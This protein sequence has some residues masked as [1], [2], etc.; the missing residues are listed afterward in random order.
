M[1][2]RIVPRELNKGIVKKVAHSIGIAG[3]MNE[4]LW[5][6]DSNHRTV[7][8]NPI[9]EELSGYS[10]EECLGQPADFCFDEESKKR[11]AEHHQLRGKGLASKYEATIVS[12]TGKRIPVLVSGAP[13][14][15]GGTIGIFLNLSKLKSLLK[16]ERIAEQ[17][18]K[19]TTDAIVVLDRKRSIKL[20]SSGAT[21]MF[22]YKEEKVMG[23]PIDILIPNDQ[24]E[25]NRILIKEVENNKYVKNVE[26]K[27]VT[28]NGEIIDVTIS[29][30]KVADKNNSFIGYLVIYSNITQQKRTSTELQKR[31]E[32]IQD[33]YKELG[34]Q[35]R[36]ADYMY[37][38]TAA[39]TSKTT[40]IK[41][42]QQLIL[43]AFSLLTKC[44]AATLR[45]LEHKGQTLKLKAGFGIDT[46]WWSKHQIKL[47]NSLAEEAFKNK[48]PIIIDE[49]DTNPKHQGIQLLKKHRLKTLI[50][51]PLH[52]NDKPMGTISLYTKDPAKFRLI[53]TDFLEKMGTQCALA[54]YAKST[55]K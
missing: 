26:A 36:Q 7:Y 12:K 37:E 42:L 10:L 34:I 23:Q 52:I 8:V 21:K 51:I 55:L 50:I 4:P 28:K 54:L 13:T 40:S 32:A 22:G 30:A 9:Y 25:K 29:V 46:K 47:E 19:H 35:K 49:I 48:R 41:A 6:G 43:S 44:D 15:E 31:F 45:M 11:I 2:P 20:W 27:R 5:L 38:V 14:A 1:N 18:V 53:E 39:A 3:A 16:K 17:V 24:L 33:A